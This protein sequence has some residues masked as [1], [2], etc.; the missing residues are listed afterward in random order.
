MEN[1]VTKEIVTITDYVQLIEAI[2]NE[3][4]NDGNKADL[5]FRGQ[6]SD[7]ELLP[8][9]A[10][11][12]LK[13]NIENI[14]RL[15]LEEF[16]RGILPLCE[17]KPENNWDLLALAQHHG[18]PTRLLDWTYSSL[19]ALW[20][21]V[22]VPAKM[23]K[24]G[25]PLDG[26]VWVL[27]PEVSDFKTNTEKIDPLTNEITKI[28]RSTVISRRIS[29]QSGLFTVHKINEGGRIVKFESH[30]SFSKKLTKVIIPH[31]QFATLRKH[32][33][34]MGVNSA[35]IFPDID[36]YC[37]HL[38]WRYSKLSDEIQKKKRS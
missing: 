28:F 31:N 33:H 29:A 35:S 13:G 17:F 21:T 27:R 10:R 5:I 34:I 12:K 24:N 14:E 9:L 18:L 4:E 15:M 19:V 20:F 38:E 16:K 26:V 2:K 30:R 11:L 23:D 7:Q 37:R 8:R 36:G 3:N 25:K 6:Q 1:Y 32:L 22:K